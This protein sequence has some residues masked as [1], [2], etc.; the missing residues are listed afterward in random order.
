MNKQHWFSMSS[1]ALCVWLL[2]VLSPA[3]TPSKWCPSVDKVAPNPP[4]TIP[5]SWTV[6]GWIGNCKQTTS[7]S[8]PWCCKRQVTAYKNPN[9]NEYRTREVQ[10]VTAPGWCQPASGDYEN[11]NIRNC[12]GTAPSGGGG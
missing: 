10:T 12:V 7:Q 8:P 4:G 11:P 2:V 6:N 1:F 9:A 3:E 5:S